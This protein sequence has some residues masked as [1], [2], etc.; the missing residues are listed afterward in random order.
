MKKD[1]KN[2]ARSLFGLGR[3]ESGLGYSFGSHL[4]Y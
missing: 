1:K 3:G 2:D 4:C